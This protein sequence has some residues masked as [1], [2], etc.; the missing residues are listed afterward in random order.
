MAKD[1]GP[2][3]GIDGEKE[4]RD[5]ISQIIQQAKTLDSEMKLVASSF[6]ATTSAEE[7]SAATK[8]V[9]AEQIKTQEE[10]V[11]LLKEQYDKSAEKLGENDEKTLK[12]KQTVMEAEASLNG[13]KKQLSDLDNGLEETVDDMEETEEATEDVGDAA[14]KTGDRLKKM[15]E[16]TV[17]AVAAIVTAAVAAGKELWNLANDVAAA[18]DE[19]DKN[20]QK[21]GLSYESY[22]K[23][24][25]A[26]QRSGTDMSSCSAGLKTLT[27]TFDDAI[28]GSSSAAEKFE[29]LGISMDDLAGMSRED[30]FAT[31]VGSLQNVSSETEKAALANDMFGKSGQDLLP[32][33]NMSAEELQG[34][35]DEADEY[36]LVMSDDAVAASAAFEDSL[37]RLQGTFNGVKNQ[38]IGELLPGI[39]DIMD[40]I[41]ALASGQENAGDQISAGVQKTVGVIE[42]LIPQAVT[43]LTQVASEVLRIAPSIISSLISGITSQLPNVAA[44]AL[45]VLL[46]LVNVLLDNLDMMLSSALTLIETLALGIAEAAPELVPTVIDVVIRMVDTLTN[47]AQLNAFISAAL[48]LVL[49]LV[50]GIV[51]AA[52]QLVGE[53]P[54]LVLQLTTSIIDSLPMIL[55]AGVQ[56]IMSL[57]TG[58]ANS[59]TSVLNAGRDIMN[60]IKA[61]I[62]EQLR[63]VGQW[64]RDLVSGFV[65][66]ILNKWNELKSSVTNLVSG[67]KN[68]FTGKQGFDTHSPSKWAAEVFDNVMTGAENSIVRSGP[69]VVKA[70]MSEIADVKDV[71]AITVSSDMTAFDGVGAAMS[72]VS[73]AAAAAA[74]AEEYN[75][76]TYNYGN[77]NIT[78]NAAEGQDPEEIAELVAARL[79]E[80][81]EREEA[82]YK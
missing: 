62:D 59:Y 38:M 23:W 3:I 12:W 42:K 56:L 5:A 30:I 71:M 77:V 53:M 60:K 29:R 6:D 13:M 50:D 78:I 76:S 18:G 58:I 37:T 54:R 70:M 34:L 19:I 67:V 32:L 49:A 25:Y 31:V 66:G 81:Y 57:L 11:R 39:T 64:G 40:G 15:A 14:D 10:R 20:S 26:M 36:G 41:A 22:Q 80:E 17:A 1:I 43:I 33:L 79:Q 24:D 16:V 9:L 73:S 4:Y 55:S 52:P 45:D 48:Q 75:D 63:N 7:K 8:R 69:K 51:R 21:V 72:P 44:A 68:L 46:E 2:R 27:N 47:P 61:G 74:R 28:N 35:M 82:V 65:N